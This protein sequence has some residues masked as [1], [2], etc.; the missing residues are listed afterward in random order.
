MTKMILFALVLGITMAILYSM[1]LIP[2]W[3]GIAI[4]W[5]GALLI[6]KMWGK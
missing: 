5:V 3:L 1:G 2:A 4:G 6:Y